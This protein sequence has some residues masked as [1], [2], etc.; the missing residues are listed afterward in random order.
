VQG[1][2]MTRKAGQKIQEAWVHSSAAIHEGAD[3][4]IASAKESAG[5][6]W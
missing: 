3:I 6:A 4:S 5:M 1:A 2:S